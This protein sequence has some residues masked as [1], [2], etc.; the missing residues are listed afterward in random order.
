MCHR[1]ALQDWDALRPSN[2]HSAFAQSVAKTRLGLLRKPVGR[3]HSEGVLCRCTTLRVEY[4]ASAPSSC[5]AR[6]E[7]EAFVLA[8]CAWSVGWSR[9]PFRRNVE[10]LQSRRAK[11]SAAS[12]LRAHSPAGK[13]R[14]FRRAEGSER[15]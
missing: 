7:C 12:R 6:L 10:A 14:Q 3:W 2:V 11:L 8:T 15:R 4:G 9:P 5:F 1:L 13:P